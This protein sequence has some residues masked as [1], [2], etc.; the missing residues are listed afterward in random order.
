MFQHSPQIMSSQSIS[1]TEDIA[2]QHKRTASAAT[3]ATYG[4][5]S[6]ESP[7]QTID[8]P[9]PFVQELQNTF[10]RVI[11]RALWEGGVPSI[12]GAGKKNVA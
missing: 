4:A 5:S 12:L 2:S 1:V 9:E 11:M 7:P 10:V 8:K 3:T 6:T